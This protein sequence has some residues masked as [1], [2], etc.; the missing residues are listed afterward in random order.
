ML[1]KS[2]GRTLLQ[3]SR[4]KCS[5]EGTV[6]G[7]DSVVLGGFRNGFNRPF[8]NKV[9]VTT[10]IAV[11]HVFLFFFVSSL[12]PSLGS[13]SS[14]YCHFLEDTR[15][16]VCADLLHWCTQIPRT[17]E[18][19]RPREMTRCSSRSDGDRSLPWDLCRI[20]NSIQVQ[21]EDCAWIWSTFRFPTPM[22]NSLA[23]K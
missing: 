21:F 10:V 22:C 16:H 12:G 14:S 23:S 17:H 5:L 13:P 7:R 3:A 4:L 8:Q 1:L 6:E 19:V 18:G 11:T 9:D 2:C 20:A 15:R